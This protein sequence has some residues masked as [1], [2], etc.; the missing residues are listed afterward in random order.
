MAKKTNKSIIGTSYHH[1]GIE[2]TVNKLKQVLGE[3]SQR[4]I[5]KSY[6]V[7]ICETENGKVFTIYDYKMYRFN[8]DTPIDFHIGSHSQVTSMLAKQELQALGL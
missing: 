7:W 8:E 1:I 5:D 2:T 4:N 3:P 6:Y